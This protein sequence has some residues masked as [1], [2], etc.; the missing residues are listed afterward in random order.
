MDS[1]LLLLFHCYK[2]NQRRC[3]MRKTIFFVSMILVIAVLTAVRAHGAITELHRSVNKMQKLVFQPLEKWQMS[4]DVTKEEALNPRFKGKKFR[5][6]GIGYFWADDQTIWRNE[7]PGQ[8]AA[9]SCRSAR[10]ADA[11]ANRPARAR[12]SG[13]PVVV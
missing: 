2:D 9:S 4:P 1:G 10:A 13:R 6:V 7:G 12:G 5:K 11:Q 8:I 3:G